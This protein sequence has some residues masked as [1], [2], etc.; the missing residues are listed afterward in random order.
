MMGLNMLAQKDTNPHCIVR[1]GLFKIVFTLIIESVDQGGEGWLTVELS[2][3]ERVCYHCAGCASGQLPSYNDSRQ[4]EL[5][6]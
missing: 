6:K 5:A 2:I 1:V 3:A 4:D